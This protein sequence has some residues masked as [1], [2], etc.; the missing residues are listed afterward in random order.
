[1]YRKRI[2]TPDAYEFAITFSPIV[3]EHVKQ[4]TQNAEFQYF[5][6][7][8]QPYYE[9]MVH[10][11]AMEIL[12]LPKK[13]SVDLDAK[14]FAKLHE[15][16]SKFLEGVRQNSTRNSNTKSKAGTLPP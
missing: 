16:N 12:Q 1:M 14:D 7:T 8:K 11:K 9:K 5:V 10:F 15:W 2:L 3:R 6:S 13:V 4:C